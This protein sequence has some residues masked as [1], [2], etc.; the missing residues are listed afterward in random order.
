LERKS[1]IDVDAINTVIIPSIAIL[2]LICNHYHV[3]LD[4]DAEDI[5]TWRSLILDRYDQTIDD[6]GPEPEYKIARRIVIIRTLEQF[7]KLSA[8]QA[9]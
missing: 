2:I 8:F 3:I 9:D 7:Q 5:L 4:L 6:F 1:K